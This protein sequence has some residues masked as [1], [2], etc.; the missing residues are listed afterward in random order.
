MRTP[1]G[2]LVGYDIGIRLGW[3]GMGGGETLMIK[4]LVWRII[5]WEG[6]DGLSE[7]VIG[8]LGVWVLGLDVGVV[9]IGPRLILK[10]GGGIV[11]L[12]GVVGWLGEV[13]MRRVRGIMKIV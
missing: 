10:R 2:L 1:F 4:G 7:C 9:W 12:T 3:I 8:G 6:I 5:G 13:G 11:G